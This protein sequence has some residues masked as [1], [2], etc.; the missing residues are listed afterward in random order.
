MWAAVL[1]IAGFL[2]GASL[3]YILARRKE[4]GADWRKLKFEQYREFILS[5]SGIVEGRA[6]AADHLRYADPANGMML[7]A[8]ARVYRA[9]VAFKDEISGHNGARTSH[10]EHDR[11]LNILVRAMRTDMVPGRDR[12]GEKSA[13]RSWAVPPENVPQNQG[14]TTESVSWMNQAGRRDNGPDDDHG[15]K[16]DRSEQ[17]LHDV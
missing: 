3:T 15:L 2:V 6:T 11:L 16:S 10:S 7:V 1:S 13:F 14:K 4:H 9:L 12:G 17:P 8:P 5:L